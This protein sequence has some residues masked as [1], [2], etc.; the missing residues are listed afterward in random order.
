MKN[1]T[2]TRLENW[3]SCRPNHKHE[4][5]SICLERRSKF[6]TLFQCKPCFQLLLQLACELYFRVI[7]MLNKVD[8]K[9]QQQGKLIK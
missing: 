3:L 6:K 4:F 5:L 2:T 9:G 7:M 1:V 8:N